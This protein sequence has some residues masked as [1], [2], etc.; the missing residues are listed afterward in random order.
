MGNFGMHYGT[1]PTYLY[2]LGGDDVWC[3]QRDHTSEKNKCHHTRL[4]V[5]K[6]CASRLQVVCKSY[7]KRFI[8]QVYHN[9]CSDLVLLLQLQF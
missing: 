7:K 5:C 4:I 9:L 2:L 6:S 1:I 3:Q 8:R